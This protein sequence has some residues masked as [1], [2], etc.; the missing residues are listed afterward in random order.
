MMRAMKP[1]DSMP[2]MSASMMTLSSGRN[3]ITRMM[4]KRRRSRRSLSAPRPP[5]PPPPRRARRSGSQEQ[6]TMTKSNLFQLS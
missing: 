2:T 5:P 4:R 6:K 3:L 1:M